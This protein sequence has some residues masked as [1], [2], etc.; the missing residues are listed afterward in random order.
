MGKELSMHIGR[1]ARPTA[2]PALSLSFLSPAFAAPGGGDPMKIGAIL[3]VT[4]PA[5]YLGAPEEKT[6]RML[7][8]EMNKGG[9]ISRIDVIAANT[10]FGNGGRGHNLPLRQAPRRRS[11]A[12]LES[13]EEAPRQIRL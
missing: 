12:R 3:A 8:D 7:V 9:G 2:F 5:A 4:G 10:G 6:V 11:A 13:A 1:I